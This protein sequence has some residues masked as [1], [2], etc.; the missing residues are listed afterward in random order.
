MEDSGILCSQLRSNKF[1]MGIVRCYRDK[2]YGLGLDKGTA[3]W[4]GG[5]GWGVGVG[6]R[7]RS[8]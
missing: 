8:A 7:E 2:H 6:G 1:S 5:G 3:E 4:G